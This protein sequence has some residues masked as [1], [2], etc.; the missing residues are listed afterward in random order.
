MMAGYQENY[1][2][3]YS[4]SEVGLDYALQQSLNTVPVEI[5]SD[6]GIQTSFDFMTQKLGFTTLVEA[7]EINGEIY[8][9]LGY[10][11]LALGG[12]THGATNIEMTAAY[13]IFPQIKVYII[14]LTHL[15]KLKMKAVKQS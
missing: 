5:M 8:T 11:Q 1:S 3:T 13:C 4:N 10:A 14:N 6:M 2:Y 9:D 15:L 7:E 12:L